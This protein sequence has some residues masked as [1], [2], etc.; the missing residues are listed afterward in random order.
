MQESLRHKD[1]KEAERT[2]IAR[3]EAA[4]TLDIN[5]QPAKLISMPIL[6]L[7][8]MFNKGIL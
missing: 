2:L 6:R 3:S 5:R 8:L 4:D 1:R 7:A